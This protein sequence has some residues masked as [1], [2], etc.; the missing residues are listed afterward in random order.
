MLLQRICISLSK[1]LVNLM[2]MIHKLHFEETLVLLIVRQN[3]FR[4]CSHKYESLSNDWILWDVHSLFFTLKMLFNSLC[5][6]VQL[7]D[8]PGY[9]SWIRSAIYWADFFFHFWFK[10]VMQISFIE[11]RILLGLSKIHYVNLIFK[12]SKT[13]SHLALIAISLENVPRVSTTPGKN[14]VL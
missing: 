12:K 7:L 3:C 6:F 1:L 11:K 13:H 5:Y 14:P 4:N 10:K 9:F 8:S 2:K